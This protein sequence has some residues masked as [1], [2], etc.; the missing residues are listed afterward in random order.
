MSWLLIVGAAGLLVYV[1][2]GRRLCRFPGIHHWHFSHDAPDKASRWCRKWTWSQG[3][4][5]CCRCRANRVRE[6]G[7]PR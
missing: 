6:T 7:H 4:F 3:V 1:F 2:L 5:E